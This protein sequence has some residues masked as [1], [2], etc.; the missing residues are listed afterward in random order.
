MDWAT[1]ACGDLTGEGAT[2][3][4]DLFIMAAE[5]LQTNSIADIAPPPDGDNIVNFADFAITALHWLEGTT[6]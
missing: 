1:L 2:D 3:I 4:D 6:P 5:W